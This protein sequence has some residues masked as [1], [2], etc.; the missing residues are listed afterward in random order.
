[1]KANFA[2]H[3]LKR[4]KSMTQ[5]ENSYFIALLNSNKWFFSLFNRKQVQWTL[6]VKRNGNEHPTRATR[7]WS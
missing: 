3:V 7:R 6:T 4:R 2:V 1:M 5:I